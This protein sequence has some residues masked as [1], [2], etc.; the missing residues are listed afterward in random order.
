MQRFLLFLFLSLFATSCWSQQ[1]EGL[2]KNINSQIYYRTYGK[3][4]PLLIING[5]PGMNSNGFVEL[6]KKL[7]TN[8][9]TI[10]YDQ[11]GT[12][13]SSLKTIN[14]TTITMALMVT[15]L[16]QLRTELKIDKWII[17][18]HSFGGM[19]A[20]YYASIHPDRIEKLILSS[21]GGIDLELRTYAANEI[22]SRLSK[23]E[24]A[25]LDSCNQATSNGD[26]TFKTRLKRGMSLAPAYIYDR[27]HIPSIAQRLTEG[28]NT[29]NSLVW[30][31][32]QQIRF[33][34]AEKLKSFTQ[35]VLIIQGKQDIVWAKTAIKANKAFKNS[36]LVFMDHC[37]HYGWLDNPEVYFES[38]NRFLKDGMPKKSR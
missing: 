4:K 12:G 9:L 10:I 6:A 31:N 19:L 38:I 16:E 33:N 35:P 5:G 22:S 26:T 8:H 17:L 34:C 37:V 13:N 25:T 3:G 18:G 7:A 30:T 20:S 21:S 23:K 36:E 2:I 15:D 28:N 1:T 27:K 14:S 24:V 11:R 32:L 29:I